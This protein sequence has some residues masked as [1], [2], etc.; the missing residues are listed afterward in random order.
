V[1]FQNARTVS[2]FGVNR[3][4]RGKPGTHTGVMGNAWGIQRREPFQGP[5]QERFASLYPQRE[6]RGDARPVRGMVEYLSDGS[7]GGQPIPH[8][9]GL[10]ATLQRMPMVRM[11]K[12]DY[13]VA[14]QHNERAV[15][16]ARALQKPFNVSKLPSPDK[17]AGLDFAQSLRMRPGIHGKPVP[18]E[19]FTGGAARVFETDRAFP[20]NP[21]VSMQPV[22][23]NPWAVQIA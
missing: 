3:D 2:Q 8:M 17:V 7:P 23:R 16:A 18:P 22:R 11:N 6:T 21:R 15:R 13:K 1:F 10:Q 4:L 5:I 9:A 19:P 20:R 14:R 12:E